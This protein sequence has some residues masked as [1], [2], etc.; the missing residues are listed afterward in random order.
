MKAAGLTHGGFY[1]HFKS[2]DDL[3]AEACTR[4]LS[5]E[6]WKG[7]ISSSATGGLE[8]LVN[9][10]LSPQH[11]SNPGRGC[12]IAAVGSDV[13]RQPRTVRR[14]FTKALESLIEGL[15]NFMPGRSSAALRKQ[16]LATLAGLV[17][18]LILSRAID[19]PA[20]SEEILEAARMRFG[21]S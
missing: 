9:A 14:A 12:L 3:A 7:A 8:A 15:N 5:R 20:L 1:G 13:A 18:A 19:G 4:A 21:H 2:K 6:W 11:R 10:Y 16:A 17:G